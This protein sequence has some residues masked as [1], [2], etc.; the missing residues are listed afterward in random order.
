[1]STVEEQFGDDN[2]LYQYDSAPCHKARSLR[3]WFLD[4]KVPGMDWPAQSPDLNPTE[5][6]WDELECLLRSRP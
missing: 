2:Y 4:S 3:E 1:M 5:N 6:L